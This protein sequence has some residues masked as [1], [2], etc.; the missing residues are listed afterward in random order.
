MSIS[1]PYI[2]SKSS[3]GT[4][5]A[6]AKLFKLVFQHKRGQPTK[7]CAGAQHLEASRV[8]VVCISDT[9]NTRPIL[10]PGDILLHAGDLSQYGLFEEIQQQL[11]WLNEQPHQHKVV[12]A[13]NHDL[14]L[15]QEFV[16]AFPDRELDKFGKA[17]ADLRW[18]NIIYLR[19]QLVK[20]R[21][22]DG[23]LNIFGSPWTPRC[24]N[25]AFQY[26]AGDNIWKDNL[27]DDVDILLTHGPPLFHLDS[28]GK[29]CPHLLDELWRI[30]PRLVVYGHIHHGRGQEVILLDRLQAVFEASQRQSYPWRY[31]LRLLFCRNAGH[32][33]LSTGRHS[34]PDSVHLVNAAIVDGPGNREH[35][36]P[37]VVTIES[38]PDHATDSSGYQMISN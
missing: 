22:R 32:S 8:S 18:G 11:D 15:D 12:I 10:P 9:H 5:T 3:R 36:E 1:R 37:I 21:V 24:G 7:S 16:K 17:F 20:V 4:N 33:D 29:G 30:R 26:E 6:V 2:P 14:I 23:C 28:G 19:H 35:R 27:P 13:G 25:F 38:K 34:G 31:L